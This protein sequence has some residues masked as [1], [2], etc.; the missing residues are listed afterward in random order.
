MTTTYRSAYWVADDCS[1]DVRL[2][3]EDEAGLSDEALMA[4]AQVYIDESGLDVMGGHIV[5]GDYTE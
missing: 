5:L 1:G 4:A 3:T 2:T